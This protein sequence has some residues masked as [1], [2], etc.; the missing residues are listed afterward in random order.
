[1]RLAQSKLLRVVSPAEDIS[2]QQ[3]RENRKI[4]VGRW[5]QNQFR[6]R[7]W[8]DP[9]TWSGNEEERDKMSPLP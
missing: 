8:Q 7:P 4:R 3:D 5:V 6:N 9:G 2:S 1:M